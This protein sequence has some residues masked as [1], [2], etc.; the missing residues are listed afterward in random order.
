MAN[1][2]GGPAIRRHTHR[3]QLRGCASEEVMQLRA[4]ASVVLALGLASPSLE[5]NARW[6]LRQ[7]GGHAAQGT[8]FGGIGVGTSQPIT[9]TE[10]PMERAG[11]PSLPKRLS[12]R[13]DGAA[14]HRRIAT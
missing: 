13:R 2:G 10:R 11:R 8:C 5:Q 6:K 4:L 1:V 3:A 9:R 12:D 7:R 14:V